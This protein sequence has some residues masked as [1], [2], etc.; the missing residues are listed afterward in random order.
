MQMGGQKKHQGAFADLSQHNTHLCR[1][2]SIQIDSWWPPFLLHKDGFPSLS[3]SGWLDMSTFHVVIF[4]NWW[5]NDF[6][7]LPVI[8]SWRNEAKYPLK[9][10]NHQ[11]KE[12]LACSLL[13]IQYCT[14]GA[15]LQETLKHTDLEK[16]SSVNTRCHLGLAQSVTALMYTHLLLMNEEFRI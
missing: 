4:P 2:C 7:P 1:A 6:F 15:L 8:I 16:M 10:F 14:L 3:A 9:N 13:L 5:L 12:T 11:E